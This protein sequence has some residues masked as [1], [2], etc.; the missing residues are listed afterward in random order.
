MAR[1]NDRQEIQPRVADGRSDPRVFPRVGAGREDDGTARP[2]GIQHRLVI[3]TPGRVP[4]AA[5]IEFQAA[6]EVDF[7]P[8][9]P[10]RLPDLRI[11]GLLDGDRV[12]R[13]VEWPEPGGGAPEAAGRAWRHPGIDQAHGQ[14]A[15]AAFEQQIRPDLALD[16][17]NLGRLE[18]IEVTTHRSAEVKR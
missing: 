4:A 6:G 18:T 15:P 9:D 2:E 17:D 5:G 14:A 11:L 10:K 1:R 8:G 7:L 13:L 3:L 16:Q 12:E